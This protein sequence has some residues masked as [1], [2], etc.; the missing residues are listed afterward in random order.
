MIRFVVNNDELEATLKLS[1]EVFGLN[2]GDDKNSLLETWLE[3]WR[4][5]FVLNWIDNDR[6]VS[7]VFVVKKQWKDSE[8]D[9]FSQ[10]WHI[11]LCGTSP[12]YRGTGIMGNL[13]E[14]ATKRC[15]LSYS[16]FLTV[17]TLPDRFTSMARFIQQQNFAIFA[18]RFERAFGQ[19]Y[20]KI[21]CY[22]P[23]LT[24]PTQF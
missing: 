13:I 18:E 6:I 2:P 7:Y 21:D 15:D 8:N 14:E 12:S 3:K 22:R 23:I 5:G 9:I 10:S 4:D 17:A 24:V 1:N 20:R 11:W 19:E 16:K